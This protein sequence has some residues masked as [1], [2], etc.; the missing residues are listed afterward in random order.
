MVTSSSF[1]RLYV[2]KLVIIGFALFTSFS[3]AETTEAG[4]ESAWSV[5]GFGSLSVGQLD[6]DQASYRGYSNE[7]S[8]KPDSLLGLQVSYQFT[9]ELS[10]TVQGTV[11]DNNKDYSDYND[12]II[13]WAFLTWLPNDNLTLK[14]GRMRAPFLAYSDVNDISYAYPW[15]TLPKQ[16]YSGWL[17]PT[18]DGI[19]VAWGSNFDEFDTSLE[20]YIGTYE[21]EKGVYGGTAKYS[22]KA[23][24]GLVGKVNYNNIQFRLSQHRGVID[25]NVQSLF[26]MATNYLDTAIMYT[27]TPELIYLR[28]SLENSQLSSKGH[29]D[30][31]QASVFYDGLEF[32]SRAE[33]VRILTNDI[34]LAPNME[35]Y[36][37]TGG[38]IT[39]PWTFSLTYAE[40]KFEYNDQIE[41]YRNIEV[42]SPLMT[43]LANDSVR[44][45]TLGTR[46]D[47]QPKVALKAEVSYIKGYADKDSYFTSIQ[48]NFDQT[49][50][51]YKLSLQWVF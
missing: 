20:T 2:N 21:N 42:L 3:S 18:Y 36:Y 1:F 40:S 37:L 27:P 32:F 34:D 17:F 51:L 16:S 6:T 41:S 31:S 25:M 39:F 30:V 8:L 46:W 48:E 14:A 12:D 15:I 50:M 10:A 24:G 35:S 47:I 45:W 9:D 29:F 28:N 26:D 19:D 43:F 44:V 7:L 49:A 5:S 4:D 33:W 38:Y 11:K 13:N 22:V 23:F